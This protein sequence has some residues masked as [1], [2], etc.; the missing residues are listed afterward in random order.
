MLE[1]GLAA[2]RWT[3]G[4]VEDVAAA[5]V[6]AATDERAASRIYNVGEPEALSMAQWVR[7]IA[8][9][10]GWEGPVVGVPSGRLPP[11]LRT[12]LHTAQD[13]MADTSRLRAEL[14]FREPVGREAGLRQAVAWERNPSGDLDPSLF[15]YGLEDDLLRDVVD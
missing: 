7:R 2:W 6:T 11:R 3:R 5:V 1:E 4:Y 15:D 8:L 9:A 14:G 12:R 10:A 13:I